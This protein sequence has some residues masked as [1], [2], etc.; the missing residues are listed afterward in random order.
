MYEP[1]L[2]IAYN[3]N[4]RVFYA[5]KAKQ[6]QAKDHL[7]NLIEREY[8]FFAFHSPRMDDIHWYLV[9]VVVF[10]ERMH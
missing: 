3:L 9:A 6:H 8:P 5:N 10:S 4:A 7:I 2:Q 1:S